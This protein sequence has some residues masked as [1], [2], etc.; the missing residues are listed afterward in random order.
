MHFRERYA[1]RQPCAPTVESEPY[2]YYTS[3]IIR[4]RRCHSTNLGPGDWLDFYCGGSLS[5]HK[6][7]SL[8]D[9]N[10]ASLNDYNDANLHSSNYSNLIAFLYRVYD[11]N[12]H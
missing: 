5:S 9:H 7:T 11:T 2:P 3:Y 8:N 4:N 10:D 6:H 1:S 12:F